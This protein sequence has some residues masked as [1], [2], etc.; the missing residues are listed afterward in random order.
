MDYKKAEKGNNGKCLTNDVDRISPQPLK[1]DKISSGK[2]K[3]PTRGIETVASS[4]EEPRRIAWD[5]I[6]KG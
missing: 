4:P 2:K 6:N 5:W 1:T 3:P